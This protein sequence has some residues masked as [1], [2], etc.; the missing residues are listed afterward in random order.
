MI[1]SFTSAMLASFVAVVFILVAALV[2]N[3]TGDAMGNAANWIGIG[4]YVMVAVL[5]LWLMI[6]HIFGIGHRHDHEDAHEAKER[7]ADRALARRHLY[8]DDHEHDHDHTHGH[9]QTRGAAMPAHAGAE[10]RH[11]AH[12][13]HAHP[14]H[15]HVAVTP[16]QLKG[17]WRESLGVVLAIGLRPCSGALVV[18]VFALS[19]GVLW[20]GIASVFLMGLGTAITV[21]ALATLAMTAKGLARRLSRGK[22]SI[23]TTLVWWG[24]LFGAFLV[25]AFG[26]LLVV[27]NLWG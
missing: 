23:A 21:A 5:G 7:R 4:S 6:R 11:S 1:L 20:A 10:H 18:L 27:A 22:A 2:L 26:I 9:D 16:D 13:A 3:L 14:V 12:E 19:Q 15:S 25:F 24:E 8:A 17:S